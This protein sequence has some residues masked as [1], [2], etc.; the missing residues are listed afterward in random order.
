MSDFGP[1]LLRAVLEAPDDD[2]P[3][4]VY[5]DWL[6]EHGDPK[7]AELIRLEVELARLDAARDAGGLST[8]EESEYDR[9]LRRLFDLWWNHPVA[10]FGHA[11]RYEVHRGFLHRI[12][13]SISSFFDLAAAVFAVHPITHV[14]LWGVGL[15][16]EG[17]PP[18]L[19]A[20]V[21]SRWRDTPAW[22]LELFPGAADRQEYRFESYEE[23][24][25]VLSRAAVAYG[26]RVAGLP[27]MGE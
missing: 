2:A 15:H 1:D 5:A 4:L 11:G 20:T 13:M 27:E 3:R 10:W 17:T 18:E 8:A 16:P 12:R 26:R 24:E 7:R 19:W 21:S 25:G 22:P 9:R 23:A 14:D 6:D